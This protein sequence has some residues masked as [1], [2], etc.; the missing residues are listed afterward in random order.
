MWRALWHTQAEWALL[1]PGDALSRKAEVPREDSPGSRLPSV[2][3]QS[4]CHRSH[5]C[6]SPLKQMSKH[7]RVIR[8]GRERGR[9][10]GG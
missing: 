6:W 7:S 10:V 9:R 5:Y 1:F 2:D 8:E 4:P 3:G